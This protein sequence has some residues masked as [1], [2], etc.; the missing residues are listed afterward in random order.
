MNR[1]FRCP[2]F[3]G[4]PHSAKFRWVVQTQFCS[5]HRFAFKNAMRANE[6]S[7]HSAP[8]SRCQ[9]TVLTEQHLFN[10]VRRWTCSCFYDLFFSQIRYGIGRCGQCHTAGCDSEAKNPLRV[11]G[12]QKRLWLTWTNSKILCKKRIHALYTWSKRMVGR[13]VLNPAHVVAEL[14]SRILE[15]CQSIPCQKL[16]VKD[17]S[18]WVLDILPFRKKTSIDDERER[19]VFAPNKM[20]IT[21]FFIV[22]IP[23]CPKV[24]SVTGPNRRYILKSNSFDSQFL[25]S[26]RLMVKQY[27]RRATAICEISKIQENEGEYHISGNTNTSIQEICSPS[28]NAQVSPLRGSLRFWMWI[29]TSCFRKVRITNKF[30]LHQNI[31]VTSLVYFQVLKELGERNRLDFER[32][33]RTVTCGGNK[34]ICFNNVQEHFSF[35]HIHRPSLLRYGTNLFGR[36]FCTSKQSTFMGTK[37]KYLWNVFLYSLSN[38]PSVLRWGQR[39]LRIGKYWSKVHI[40]TRS[41]FEQTC[42]VS[43]W[44]FLQFS[45]AVKPCSY[46]HVGLVQRVMHSRIN[47]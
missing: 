5:T 34:Y 36:L 19:K 16:G 17:Q 14:I 23:Y 43:H 47:L 4:C 9:V 24:S 3:V 38:H 33:N 10:I 22:R 13:S 41:K 40:H 29:T 15:E 8:A 35:L 18:A 21:E 20:D 27:T 26:F 44:K 32:A 46:G 31:C 6:T 39:T 11:E 25:F 28:E 42:S 37:A 1:M 30:E 12:A 7:P 2:I 45:E